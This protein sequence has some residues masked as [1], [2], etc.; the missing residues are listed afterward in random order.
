MNFNKT[1]FVRIALPFILG[2]I[3]NLYFDINSLLSF[4]L[5]I[6]FSIT[7]AFFHFAPISR[8][9]FFTS[10]YGYSLFLFFFFSGIFLSE[11]RE[12]QKANIEISAENQYIATI[13]DNLQESEKF[14]KTLL[15]VEEN[16]TDSTEK[17]T[18]LVLAYFRKDKKVA[19][20]QYGDKI[21]FSA[22][23]QEIKPKGNPYEFDF[24]NYLAKRGVFYQAFLEP[25][26]FQFLENFSGFSIFFIANNFRNNLLQIYKENNIEGAELAVLSAL[27]LGYKNYLSIET[28]QAFTDSGA[29]HILSVSGLHVGIILGFLMLIFRPFG[30]SS[31]I[32][33]IKVIVI[34]FSLWAFALI[35]GLSPSVLRATLMFTFVA[36]GDFINRSGSIYNSLW[37][38]AS[39]LLLYSPINFFDIGFQLSY[40]AVFSIVALQPTIYKS[41]Y[42]PTKLG[43]YTWELIS[44][45]IA[46]QLGTLPISLLYFNQFPVYFILT[47][48]VVIPLSFFITYLAIVLLFTAKITL[49]SKFLGTILYYS[50]YLLN[51]S[52][53]YIT[54]LPLSTIQ[55]MQLNL[56]EMFLLY[57]FI[58]FLFL[59]FSFKRKFYLKLS[60]AFLLIVSTSNIYSNYKKAQQ[61]TFVVFN[62]NK[63]TMLN[64]TT[65]SENIIVCDSTLEKNKATINFAAKNFWTELNVVNPMI[66]SIL[67]L[68]KKE[69]SFHSIYFDENFILF[70]NKKIAILGYNNLADFYTTEK[71]KLDYLILAKNTKI[72]IAEILEFYEVQQIIIDSSNSFNKI[73]KWQEDASDL[74]VDLHIVPMEG[75][76]VAIFE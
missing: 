38:S 61:N 10:F 55:G 2:I 54:D 58:I 68:E 30:S 34:V 57:F 71:L 48:I 42:V 73:K 63:S 51:Y 39:L 27:T 47:N 31:R 11:M 16:I 25:D 67:N 76:F 7:L 23:L 59:F 41:L 49:I 50:V 62:I 3:L 15:K 75:A 53:T 72:T 13:D 1:P 74:G 19:S 60:F 5:L 45:S 14:Y 44:V 66:K 33:L 12:I 18:Y 29:M 22:K 9:Y 46:A 17:E 70:K 64:F 26:R 52:V 36:I 43:N 32:K 6:F 56:I 8:N 69:N 4:L 28:K 37:A 21:L 40:L 65:N 35:S 24:P 20:L